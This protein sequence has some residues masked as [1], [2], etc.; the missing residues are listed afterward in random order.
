VVVAALGAGTNRSCAETGFLWQ[1]REVNVAKMIER[2]IEK[3][4]GSGRTRM[5]P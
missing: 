1:R 2:E 5:L 4:D 3:E